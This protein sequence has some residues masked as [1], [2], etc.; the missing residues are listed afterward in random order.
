MNAKQKAA[1]LLNA[2][3]EE[4]ARITDAEVKAWLAGAESNR[5]IREHLEELN[6]SKVSQTERI[7]V[8]RG[9]T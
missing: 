4:K 3:I 9:I 6:T 2:T 1:K 7:E 5:D 8:I